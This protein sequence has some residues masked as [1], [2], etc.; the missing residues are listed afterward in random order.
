M[1]RTPEEWQALFPVLEMKMTSQSLE[2]TLAD[3]KAHLCATFPKEMV[4]SIIEK[5]QAIQSGRVKDNIFSRNYAGAWR[6]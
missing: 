2:I 1:E 3:D 6:K 5:W 4:E